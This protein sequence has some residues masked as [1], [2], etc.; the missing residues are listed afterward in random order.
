[1]MMRGCAVVAMVLASML[2]VAQVGGG[3]VY[4]GANASS[5]ESDLRALRVESKA[6]GQF[7]DAVVLMN[8]RPDAY[9]GVF[10][11]SGFG[12]TTVAASQA[13]D[14]KVAKFQDSAQK[15]GFNQSAFYVDFVASSRV[16]GFHVTERENREYLQGFRVQK[17]VSIVFHRLGLVESLVG[18]AQSADL[19]LAGLQAQV[20][21][22]V[23]VRTQL[24]SEASKVIKQKLQLYQDQ[25]Q[26]KKR[27]T[28]VVLDRMSATFP[29]DR[30]ASYSATDES[31]VS[32]ADTTKRTVYLPR[33]RAF[34]YRPIDA[35]LF[36]EVL[37]P[38]EVEPCVQFGLYLRVK[39]A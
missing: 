4:S 16:N 12:S 15:L 10:S 21:N 1:M 25:F 31:D 34:Y 30:Y 19:E 24:F 20:T 26:L 14:S 6:D 3:S 8:V 2:A 22:I 35:A 28:G 13:V 38:L 33:T 9:I 27:V 7:V 36:D 23:S 29:I 18:L 37:R 39:V 32:L 5:F 17:T 11:A